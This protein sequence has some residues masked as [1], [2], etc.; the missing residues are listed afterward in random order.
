MAGSAVH[1]SAKTALFHTA[2]VSD[3]DFSA[4]GTLMGQIAPGSFEIERSETSE[5]GMGIEAGTGA[6]RRITLRVPGTGGSWLSTVQTAANAN[7]PTT[8]YLYIVNR[9]GTGYTQYGPG[10]FVHAHQM[11]KDGDPTRA[12][13][14]VVFYCEGDT[15]EDIVTDYAVAYT[16]P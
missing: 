5:A 4:T 2:V 3:G 8:E 12:A 13:A 14:R 7:P 11:G 1:N 16:S 10:N 15:V 9:S 6:S